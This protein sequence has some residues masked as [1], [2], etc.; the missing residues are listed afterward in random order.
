MHA[1]VMHRC[2]CTDQAQAITA[3]M[4]K[5]KAWTPLLSRALGGKMKMNKSRRRG[6]GSNNMFF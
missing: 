2:M 6:G 1:G 4:F 3:R 5:G